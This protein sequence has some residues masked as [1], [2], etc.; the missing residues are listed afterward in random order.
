MKE[1]ETDK[2]NARA[3]KSNTERE[4]DVWLVWYAGSVCMYECASKMPAARFFVPKTT[5]DAIDTKPKVSGRA[6]EGANTQLYI[7]YILQ[8]NR[9]KTCAPICTLLKEYIY[10]FGIV[11]MIKM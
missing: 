8:R 10:I 4:R 1:K 2:A 7:K 9:Q 3:R 5:D 6:R 11:E